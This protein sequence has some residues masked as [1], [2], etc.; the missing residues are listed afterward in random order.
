MCFTVLSRKKYCTLAA[1]GFEA[2][3]S[4]A[5]SCQP[6]LIQQQIRLCILG[7][8]GQFFWVAVKEFMLNYHIM[9]IQ[10][11]IWLLDDEKFI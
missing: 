7:D 2:I 9:E 1:L 5:S 3:P 4:L 11:V 10:Y 8:M 6:G